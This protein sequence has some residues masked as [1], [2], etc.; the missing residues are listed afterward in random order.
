MASR[1]KCYKSLISTYFRKSTAHLFSELYFN[2]NHPTSC[3]EVSS[4]T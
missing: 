4:Q 1:D 3:K 2:H